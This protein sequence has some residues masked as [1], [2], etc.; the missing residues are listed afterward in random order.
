M[1]ADRRILDV[2]IRRLEKKKEDDGGS[3]YFFL[4]EATALRAFISSWEVTDRT[5]ALAPHIFSDLVEHA[6][7]ETE[8]SIRFHFKCGLQLTESVRRPE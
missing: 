2:Y 6:E 8:V 7:V 4:Q 1:S 5:E 3:P